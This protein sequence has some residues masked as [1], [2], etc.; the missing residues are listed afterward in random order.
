MERIL[1]SQT[2]LTTILVEWATKGPKSAHVLYDQYD[3]FCIPFVMKILQSA[4]NRP[5]LIIP[6]FRHLFL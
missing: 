2:F 3:N 1:K 5:I 6:L 4:F